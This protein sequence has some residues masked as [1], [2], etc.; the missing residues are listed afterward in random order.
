MTGH[1]VV[2]IDP[3]LTCTGIAISDRTLGFR[4]VQSKPSG[5]DLNARAIR[6]AGLAHDIINA[7]T[8]GGLPD[9]V[10][11]ESPSMG[12]SR[13]TSAHAHD[14]SGLWWQVVIVAMGN[15]MQ[16]P[17]LEIPPACRAKYAT[18]K[19]N[20]A[21]GAVIDAVAR[22]YPQVETGGNDNLADALILA[23]I[24]RRMIGHPIEDSLP[25]A[26]LAALQTL[27]LPE[28]FAA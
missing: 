28:G 23:A 9:L 7:T 11:I 6:I 2:G 8:L 25:A 18:G 22:R 17:V 3:S 21:K 5:P 13:G 1:R 20:S 10:V 14:R 26:N 12:A 27:R 16:I 19:G 4:T 24:G 15:D